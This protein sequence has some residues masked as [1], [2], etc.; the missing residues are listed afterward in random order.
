MK[1]I[2]PLTLMLLLSACAV[3]DGSA[4][5]LCSIP[6]PSLDAEGISEMNAEELDLFVARYEG[7]CRSL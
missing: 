5:A 1:L 3:T 2:V 7:V 6:R 4:K